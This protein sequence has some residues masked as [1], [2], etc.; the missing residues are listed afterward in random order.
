MGPYAYDG[1]QWVG[2]DDVKMARTKAQYVKTHGLGG[3][4][5]WAIDLA[6]F[7]GSCSQGRYNNLYVYVLNCLDYQL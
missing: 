7:K 3:T 6:D 5:V 4:M 1:N 2:Y